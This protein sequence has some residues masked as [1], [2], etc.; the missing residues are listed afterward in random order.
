MHAVWM[1]GHFLAPR[2]IPNL[3]FLSLGVIGY[4][5]GQATEVKWNNMNSCPQTK[6]GKTLLG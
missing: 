6:P 5:E 2:H 4:A 1:L 3:G